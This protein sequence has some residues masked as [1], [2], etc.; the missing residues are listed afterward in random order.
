MGLPKNYIHEDGQPKHWFLCKS[1]QLPYIPLAFTSQNSEHDPQI[2]YVFLLWFQRNTYLR[3]T[4]A[5]I[6]KELKIT[7]NLDKLLEYKISWIKHVNRIPRNRLARVMKYYSP[8]GKRNHGR[9]LKRL[10]DTWDRNG[11]T[12]DQ[13]PWKIYDD[14]DLFEKC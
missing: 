8:N 4:N 10:L 3:K 12:S 9:S 1:D 14:D 2:L 5:Q 7:P 11:S 6:A 13:T